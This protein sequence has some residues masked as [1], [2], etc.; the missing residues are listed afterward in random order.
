MQDLMPIGSKFPL[1]SKKVSVLVGDPIELDDLVKENTLNFASKAELY[2]AIAV[3]VGQRMQMM[4]EE[5]DQLIAVRELQLAAEEA[6]R[7]PAIEKAQKLL[8]YIDWEAQ[9]QLPECD[10][11]VKEHFLDL[12]LIRESDAY[13]QVFGA[14]EQLSREELSNKREEPSVP[15][16]KISEFEMEEFFELEDEW[17]PLSRPSILSRVRGFV[18]TPTFL[19][20]GFAARGLL[21][22]RK[23]YEGSELNG[24]RYWGRL[25]TKPL[26]QVG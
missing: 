17:D 3:R 14:R 15:E 22:S 8:Q 25:S 4:K 16:Q 9:G 18:D 5:L 24:W 11:I 13:A 6:R 21:S 7:H 12:S 2:D 23:D 10:S 26:N 19:G 1:V 20:L